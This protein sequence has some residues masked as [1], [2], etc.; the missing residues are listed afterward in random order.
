MSQHILGVMKFRHKHVHAQGARLP[1]EPECKVDSFCPFLLIEPS[2]R[3]RDVGRMSASPSGRART[4][5]REEPA[6]TARSASAKW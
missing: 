2:A 1:H 4:R 3:A 5:T 6:C